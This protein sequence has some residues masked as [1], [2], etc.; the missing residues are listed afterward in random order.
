MKLCLH[1][2][3]IVDVRN[4]CITDS[5]DILIENGRIL[6]IGGNLKGDIT[7]DCSSLYAIPGMMDPHGHLEVFYTPLSVSYP[8]MLHGTTSA[9]TETHEFANIFGRYGV[10][11]LIS[12]ADLTPFRIF[13]TVGSITP[14]NP[15]VEGEEK[16]PPED[17]RELMKNDRVVG[18][19]EVISWMRVLKN[20]PVM[21]EKI[22]VAKKFGKTV[23]GHMAGAKGDKI[24]KLAKAG[25]T[26]CHESITAD[27]VFEK[28]EAGIHVIIREGSIRREME[29]IIPEIVGHEDIFDMIMLSP[30][31]LDPRDLLKFGYMDY[32]VSR[33]VELGLNPITAIKMVTLN[34]AEYFGLKHLGRIERG[35]SADIILV[36][37]ISSP[38]PEHAII[39][40]EFVVK[41]GRLMVDER[42][43]EVPEKIRNSVELAP[44]L[45]LE[46]FKFQPEEGVLNYMD[47]VDRTITRAESME[48]EGNLPENISLIRLIGRFD[49]KMSPFGAIRGFSIEGFASTFSQD[50]HNLMIIGNSPSAMAM[51]GN[52]VIEMRGGFAYVHEGEIKTLEMD[53]GG[54]ASSK[55]IPELSDRLEDFELPLKEITGLESPLLTSGFLTFSSL[56]F[57]RMT[58]KGMYDVIR[59][60]IIPVYEKTEN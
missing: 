15:H 41:D 22:E 47:V 34:P 59:D 57:L 45:T 54:I 12:L 24:R 42:R 50:C 36:K 37:N 56:P 51:A 7:F 6:E 49:G 29:R 19:G 23:E 13:Y 53:V 55:S 21:M 2:C 20:D 25:I 39:G 44:E 16:L 52:A 33:A 14:Q 9:V 32:I 38:T 18:L 48:I 17:V 35:C 46:D 27:E 60:R 11:F 5:C 31:W 28:L 58:P 10:E 30:D 1:N 8:A 26:S 4:D 40:G 3:R 43:I